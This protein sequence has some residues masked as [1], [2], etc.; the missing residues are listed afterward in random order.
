MEAIGL[1]IESL[2]ELGITVPAADRLAGELDH[3]FDHLY[4]W[5]D[6]AEAADDRARPD[7]TEPTLLTAARLLSAVGPAGGLLRPEPRHGRLV[8]PGGAA[9]LARARPGPAP[10]SAPPPSPLWRARRLRRRLRGSSRSKA[11]FTRFG[12]PGKASSPVASWP[13]SATSTT[14]PSTTCWMRANAGQ[15]RRRGGGGLAFV[16]RTDSEQTGQVLDSYRWLAVLRGKAQT[17]GVRRS[18]RQVRQQPAGASLRLCQPGDR[19]RPSRGSRTSR[20]SPPR[21]PPRHPG[22]T[23]RG[24][25]VVSL[26]HASESEIPASGREAFERRQFGGAADF[27]GGDCARRVSPPR[28]PR[29]TSPRPGTRTSAP[30]SSSCPPVP[31]RALARANARTKGRFDTFKN[32]VVSNMPGPREPRYLGLW[33]VDFERLVWVFAPG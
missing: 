2:R 4:R 24:P 3:Q 18:H 31:S 26:R 30:S 23:R 25:S 16:R 32:V 27:T 33:R 28:R 20:Q 12:G 5:L 29:S 21:G 11:D 6:H 13:W 1:G 10:C 15:L 19:G 7:I 17:Q 22:R 8:E 14:R 9:D